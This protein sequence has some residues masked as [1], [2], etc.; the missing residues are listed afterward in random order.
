MKP[1]SIFLYLYNN[2]KECGI[3]VTKQSSRNIR[4]NK[5]S[6]NAL[7]FGF[8]MYLKYIF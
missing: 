6:Y 2:I 8:K 7:I 4:C 1:I 5:K 3:E